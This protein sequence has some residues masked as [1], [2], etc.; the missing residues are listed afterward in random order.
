MAEDF[1]K[2]VEDGLKLSKRLYFGKD[3]AVVPPKQPVFME[4]SAASV[5]LP[6]APMVY[7]V[8][9]DPGIV[10]NPDMPSYQPHVHGRC[11]PPAL[12]PLQMNR[13]ELHA[14]TFLDTAFVRVTGSWRV[15]CV[16]GSKACDCKLAI[17]LGEQGSILGVEVE[18]SRKVYTTELI[19]VDD[20]KK[21]LDKETRHEN[22]GFLT[23]YIFTLAI[24][25]VDGG[26]N[27]SITMNWMQKLLYHDGEFSLLVP[28]NFPDYVTPPVK[29]LPKKE[30]IL[31]NVNC[32][33]GSE[34]LCKKTSYP[35]KEVR[36]EAGRLGL[37][38]EA[39]VL[40]WTHNDLALSYDVSSGH[41]FG[42]V[43]LQS[44]PMHD[45]D[46]REMFCVYLFPGG[47]QSKKVFRKEMVFVVDISGSMEGKPL[48]DTKNELSAAL[49]KLDPKDSFNIIAFNGETYT[50]SSSMQ[51][52]SEQAVDRAVQ[53][54]DA[55]F[56]AGGGT[57][58]LVPLN[59]AIG[60]VSGTH[61][62]IPMI[63]LVTDGAVKDERHICDV[64]KNHQTR[65]EA[66]SP[67]TFCNHH[68][69]RTL[70][71]ISGGQYNAA[72]DIDSIESQM[73][74]WLSGASSIVLGNISIDA[75]DDL[76]E[77]EVYPS[78]IPDL[79]SEIPWIISGRYK[80]NFNDTPKVKGVLGDLSNFV[81]DLKIQEAKD[82]PLNQISAKQQI[83]LLTA[84]SWLSQN[85]QL[86][87][88]VSSISIE[89]GIASEYTLMTLLETEGGNQATES[90]GSHKS[91]HKS[92]SSKVGVQGQ[93]RR[94]LLQNLGVGF[95]NL[96]ATADN[97]PPGVEQPKLPE[98]AEIIIKAAS[99]CCGKMFSHC[100]CMCCI[101]CCNRMNDQCA[102]VLAQLCTAL[103]CF[104]CVECCTSLCCGDSQGN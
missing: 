4:K 60:M 24:P 79:S 68:F 100:C 76:E 16:M 78:L 52:A 35:F 94:I 61:G 103:A 17:P 45:V 47:Q 49:L 75:F 27:I 48:E 91:K 7:A 85:K 13:I 74:K 31:V 42:G 15:H 95:G 21:D 41:I 92:D 63:F 66:M 23:P 87:K 37:V 73:Q 102:T 64:V 10:D 59:K 58:I 99:N 3:R 71:M 5:Y 33:T 12:I 65:E 101:Q 28:F 2:S 93:R 62:S 38:Y 11:D 82:T 14:D 77:V 20:D 86:E 53:W 22:G 29:K 26:T 50:F 104:G 57:D 88:K 8:V 36:R 72:Y 30:K 90:S 97:I 43:L 67:R 83:D 19:A 96:T 18:V 40:T 54:M 32:G 6:T 25:K 51:L 55:N 70:A 44:P 69:L 56:I 80:G 9:S 34:I 46:Q 84:Q 98:A 1:G 39:E 89:T 81:I